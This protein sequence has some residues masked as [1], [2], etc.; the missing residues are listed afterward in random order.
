MTT[1]AGG[2]AGIIT[3]NVRA[4]GRSELHFPDL[5]IW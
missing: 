2:A 4:F 3:K 1:L 5:R